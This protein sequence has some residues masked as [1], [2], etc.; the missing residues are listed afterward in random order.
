MKILMLTTTEF[1]FN[2]MSNVIS[3]YVDFLLRDQ[4][5]QVDILSRGEFED[6][7][8]SDFESKGCTCFGFNKIISYS[9]FIREYKKIVSE[10]SYDAIHIHANSSLV[11]ILLK[12]AKKKGIKIRIV[13]SHSTSCNFPVLNKLLWK[14]INK[15]ATTKLACSD[16]AG[17]HMFGSDDFIF[18]PNAVDVNRCKFSEEERIKIRKSYGIKNEYLIGHIA[19]FSIAKNHKFLIKIL[20]DLKSK[21]FDYKAILIGEGP[22]KQEIMDLAKNLD[23]EDKII[24]AGKVP[25]AYTYMSAMDL[26]VL[27]SLYEGLPVC[28]IEAQSVGVPTI[29]SD[30]ISNQI[31]INE[32]AIPLSIEDSELW[33]NEII[34]QELKYDFDSAENLINSQFSHY[35]VSKVICDLYK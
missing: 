16:V 7:Y 32:N 18:V 33:A 27:P 4:K 17:R 9:K 3:N 14:Q 8:K 13:H 10:N 20:R 35:S 29:Y 30:T 1:K 24:F 15:Y 22:M 25:N 23:V 19:T 26:F 31:K 6:F 21:E 2:G 34:K 5:H 12:Y 28:L 11:Y